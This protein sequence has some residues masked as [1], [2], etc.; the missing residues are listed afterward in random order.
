MLRDPENAGHPDLRPGNP[1]AE[2]ARCS[3]QTAS[4]ARNSAYY[5]NSACYRRIRDFFTIFGRILDA[6][7][8]QNPNKFGF[9]FGL[10]DFGCAQDTSARQNTQINLALYPAYSSVF[11]SVLDT[12]ASTM[13]K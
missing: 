8:Q 1:P 3:R 13:L 4:G 12:L 5:R 9:V 7:P 11:D 10:F 2:T 6:S